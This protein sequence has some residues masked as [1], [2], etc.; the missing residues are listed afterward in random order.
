[1]SELKYRVNFI[2]ALEVSSESIKLEF[3][4]KFQAEQALDAMAMLLLFMQDNAM[5][6]DFS[7]V[8][9]IEKLVDGEWEEVDEDV[10]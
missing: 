7:N 9:W 10:E 1:M 5:M 4:T 6:N 8:A 3:A 2:P